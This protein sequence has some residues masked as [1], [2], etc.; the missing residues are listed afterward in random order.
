M[1]LAVSD[2]TERDYPDMTSPT[3][4]MLFKIENAKLH[5]TAEKISGEPGLVR[6]FVDEGYLYILHGGITVKKL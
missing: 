6:A 4:Y 5:L 2:H 3:V 1:G